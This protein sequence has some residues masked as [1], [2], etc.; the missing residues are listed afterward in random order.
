AR[1]HGVQGHESTDLPF[2]VDRAVTALALG[3]PVAA[4][5]VVVWAGGLAAVPD[6]DGARPGATEP[7]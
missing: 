2:P 4:A 7:G 5:A 3:V 1:H 6:D